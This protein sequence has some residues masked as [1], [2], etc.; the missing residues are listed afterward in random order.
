MNKKVIVPVVLVLIVIVSSMFLIARG[1]PSSKNVATNAPVKEFKMTSFTE[2]VNGEPKP[3][4][5]LNEIVVNKGD[6]VRIKITETSGMHNFVIDEFGVYKDTPLNQESVV[7]FIADKSGNFVY[8]C[9]KPGHRQ[10]GQ[11]G[12]LRVL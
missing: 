7:E 11:W 5:S 3:H 12:T 1:S 8:Y 10:N 2:M 6:K 9:S 4:F